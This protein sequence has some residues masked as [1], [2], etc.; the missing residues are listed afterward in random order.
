[1]IK[2]RL[3]IRQIIGTDLFLHE[4]YHIY[5]LLRLGTYLHGDL[6]DVHEM[7]L[8]HAIQVFQISWLVQIERRRSLY[9]GSNSFMIATF[10][11][12]QVLWPG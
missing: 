4:R 12:V 7:Q 3:T 10:G 11:N 1:M 2:L 8:L 5:Y 6:D 9:D